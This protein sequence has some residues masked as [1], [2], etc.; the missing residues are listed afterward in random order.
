MYSEGGNET[1]E[2][3]SITELTLTRTANGEKKIPFSCSQ[4]T[5]FYNHHS[6][7]TKFK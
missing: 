5:F 6:K 1:K 3:E 7:N 2:E 4:N